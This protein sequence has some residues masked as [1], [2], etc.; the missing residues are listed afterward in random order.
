[1]AKK[2]LFLGA[3]PTQMSPLRYARE[4]GHHV[5]TC[6]YL[7]ENPGHALAN[8]S[9]NVSTTDK[10]A[11]LALAQRLK[12]DAIVAYA[13]DP[14]APTAAYV[15][16]QMGL[17]GNPYQA[18]LTLARKDLFRA[19][20]KAHDFNVPRS[21]SFY[22]RELGRAWLTEIGVPAYIKPVDSSGSKGVTRLDDFA[23]FDEAF[24][25]ALT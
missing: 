10:D 6:D 5:I 11:I 19:F 23:K 1:M 14:A 2:I 4:Q 9:Y 17:P 16:E 25:H 3:A 24:D 21:Q 13:S 22:D 15:A 7:P 20:L 12:I 18:V 8:E